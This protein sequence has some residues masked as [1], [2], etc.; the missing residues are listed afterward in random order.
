M[1]NKW[2]K[3]LL[4]VVLTWVILMTCQSVLQSGQISLLPHLVGL[5]NSVEKQESLSESATDLEEL[6]VET[7]NGNVTLIGSDNTDE[8]R[9]EAYYLARAASQSA[10]ERKLDQISTDLIRGTNRLTIGAVFSSSKTGES[11]SY[12]ITLPHALLVQ[13]KTS[14]G[15]II[16]ENLTG[17][18]TLNTSNGRITVDSEEGPQGLVAR[19]SNGGITVSASPK[20]GHYDLR[21]S[22]GTVRVNLPEELGVSL[23]AKTSNG[24]INLGSGNWSFE[25]G[26]I[27]KNQVDAKRG[28]GE[29]ELVITTSNGSI[30]LQD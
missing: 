18:L 1:L 30:T 4:I 12:T 24:S 23:S 7:Q 19:T 5:D 13:G 22:N 11:I 27:S 16:A 9:V 2:A 21:T 20:G 15:N 29:L 25:G 3:A 14:N 10:A 6:V 26:R 28:N 17:Q 8:I